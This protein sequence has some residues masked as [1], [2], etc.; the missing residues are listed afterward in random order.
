MWRRSPPL[1]APVGFPPRT[2]STPAV[3]D[4]PG[5]ALPTCQT[6]DKHSGGHGDQ[7]DLRVLQSPGR[8]AGPFP[9]L[10]G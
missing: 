10:F 5:L 8:A 9:G 4:L 7:R 3:N 1:A 6:I 2:A